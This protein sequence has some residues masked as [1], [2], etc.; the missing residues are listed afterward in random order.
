MVEGLMIHDQLSQIFCYLG[1]YGYERLHVKQYEEESASYR[2]IMREYILSYDN[3]LP[4]CKVTNPD[5]IP[6]VIVNQARCELRG[7]T[8][9]Q[10]IE[11]CFCKWIEW[12]SDT[13]N[14][15]QKLYFELMEAKDV[16]SAA[17]LSDRIQDV[18]DELIRAKDILLWLRSVDFDPIAISD[19]Q[20]IY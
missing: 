10:L 2:E 11:E 16:S 15:Y 14:L 13:K 3:I 1:L 18:S 4:A 20:T 19:T 7:S 5:V 12:E 17:K 8:R 9:K 6:S